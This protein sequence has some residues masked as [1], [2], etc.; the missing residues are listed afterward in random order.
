MSSIGEY[1]YHSQLKDIAL[2]GMVRADET[3]VLDELDTGGKIV[4][5]FRGALT[6]DCANIKGTWQKAGATEKL[7]FSV[8]MQSSHSG[9]LDHRYGI[10][11]YGN[12]EIVHANAYKFW[13]S[14]KNGD[15]KAVASMMDYPVRAQVGGKSRTFRNAKAFMASYDAIFTPSFRQAVVSSVPHNMSA[16]TGG[17]MLGK[18][19]EVWLNHMG[20]VKSFNNP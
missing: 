6:E 14:V 2:K 15:R 17:I 1:F 19:G 5:S 10:A 7:P 13:L 20:K 18:T 16:D 9:R 11:G 12:D 3:I 4:A 8:R